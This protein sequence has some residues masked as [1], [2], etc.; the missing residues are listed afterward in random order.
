MNLIKDRAE[1]ENH[2]VRIKRLRKDAEFL[3]YAILFSD[4]FWSAVS[5]EETKNKAGVYVISIPGEYYKIGSSKNIYKRLIGIERSLPFSIQVIKIFE[6][7]FYKPIEN[8]IHLK[9]KHRKIKTEWFR[10]TEIDI[11]E[12]EDI[13]R[14]YSDYV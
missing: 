10:L 2:R 11:A 4:D 1:H 12:M 6:T 3:S 14:E 9:L 13:F 7:P 5:L 8:I